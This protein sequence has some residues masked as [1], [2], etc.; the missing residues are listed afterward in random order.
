[1]TGN[2]ASEGAPGG[3]GDFLAN[4]L[5][6]ASTAYVAPSAVLV[7]H[8]QVGDDS[9]VWPVA[10]LRGDYAPIE[11]GSESNVQDGAVLHVDQNAPC[12][13]GDRVTVGHRAVVH[14]ATVE[15]DCLVGI[16]AVI[17]TGARIGAGSLVGA[18]AV[19]PE[20]TQIPP[21]SLVLGVP[22]RVARA[23]DRALEERI[24]QSAANYVRYA[25]AYRE[26]RLG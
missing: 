4:R 11:V 1:M 21:G 18:G 12:R 20:G 25:R 22:G 13:L 10:V 3:A 7:G 9:S 6:I 5:A 23:V 16:G 14:G 17:L 24:R 8:V 26:G 15:D 19:V 2:R